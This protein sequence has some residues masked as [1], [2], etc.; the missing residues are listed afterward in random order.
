MSLELK[1]RKML[2][3]EPLSEKS[4]AVN[5]Q[6]IVENLILKNKEEVV[7]QVRTQWKNGLRP[8]G[9]IIGIYKSFAYNREKLAQN[10]LA[11]GNVDLILTGDLNE[12]LTLNKLRQ[13]MFSIFSTDSK[14]VSIAQKYGL[15]V[16]GM[17]PDQEIMFLDNIVSKAIDEIIY[18][19]Y[20]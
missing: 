15:D 10:P 6:E 1:L 18:Y 7:E 19:I 5:V 8:S 14:A 9:E 13:G 12:G 3:L 20:N 17:N 16:Y 2:Y 11:G 4:K